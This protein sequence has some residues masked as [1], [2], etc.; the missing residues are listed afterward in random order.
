MSAVCVTVFTE[1][2]AIRAS[3]SREVKE[4]VG[5]DSTRS[6]CH[7]HAYTRA[8]G[9]ILHPRATNG[10]HVSVSQSEA[11][12]RGEKTPL[13]D[14]LSCSEWAAQ[15]SRSPIILKEPAWLETE[16]QQPSQ[17]NNAILHKGPTLSANGLCINPLG[18]VLHN[19]H[20]SAPVTMLQEVNL[21]GWGVARYSFQPFRPI[22]ILKYGSLKNP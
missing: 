19:N 4:R 13:K 18:C 17:S 12:L 5:S 10:Q 8:R 1:A 7:A 9:L 21:S 22:C 6:T 2:A 15:T 11:H 20:N 16:S 14:R 3:S